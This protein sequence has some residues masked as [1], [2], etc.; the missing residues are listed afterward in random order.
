MRSSHHGTPAG[1]AELDRREPPDVQLAYFGL[2]PEFIGKGL[3]GFFLDWAV[4]AASIDQRWWCETRPT[5]TP[6]SP[7]GVRPV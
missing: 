5:T 1:Y 2:M 7:C 3:G 4:R 6:D